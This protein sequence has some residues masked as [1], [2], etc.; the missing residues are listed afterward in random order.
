MMSLLAEINQLQLQADDPEERHIV[1]GVSWEQYEALLCRL[2]DRSG[3]RITYLEGVLEIMSPSRRHEVSKENIGRLLE[4]YFEETR[5]RFWGLGSTTFRKQE[6]RGGKEP[7][8]CYCIGTE[9]EFPDLAIE[10]ATSG[11]ID[12]L[13]VYKRLGVREVWFWQ[14]NQFSVYSLQRDKYEQVSKSELLP[15]LDLAL[16]ADYVKQPDPLEAMLE[17][18]ERIRGAI[19]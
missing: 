14:N 10:V 3:Y 5:T 19:A 1:T 15:K 4:V 12:T 6:K 17:F 7:D 13:E 2:G 9:K 16:L 11:G 8:K 18:R